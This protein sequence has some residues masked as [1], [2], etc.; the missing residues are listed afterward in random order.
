LQ[1]TVAFP[2]LGDCAILK[3]NRRSLCVVGQAF[4]QRAGKVSLERLTYVRAV[5]TTGALVDHTRSEP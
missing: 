4:F 1:T 2:I 3:W 5:P